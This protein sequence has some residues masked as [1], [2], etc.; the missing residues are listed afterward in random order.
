[1][2]DH[3]LILGGLCQIKY[4]E[5]FVPAMA[6]PC[7]KAAAKS[8]VS[9]LKEFIYAHMTVGRLGNL[10]QEASYLALSKFEIIMLISNF[11]SLT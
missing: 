6:T 8:I 9:V 4:A 11:H 7:D 3:C 2:K 5:T 10:F 1:M